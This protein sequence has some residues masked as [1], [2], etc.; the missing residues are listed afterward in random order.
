MTKVAILIP[1]TTCGREWR[2]MEDTYLYN[3]TLKTFLLSRCKEDEIEYIFYIGYDDGDKIL[4]QKC[5]Q[6]KIKKFEKVF[7]DIN[8]E[9]VCFQEIPKGYLT[10]MWN[11]LFKRAYIDGADY[12]FQCGDDINF[13]TNGWVSA[14]VETLKKH[15]NIGITGPINN[16]C[17]IL[18][19][20]MVSR[21]HMDIFGYF[22]PE[23]IK[24]W[25]CDDWYNLVYQPKL[26][27]P[28]ANHYCSNEGGNPRYVINNDENFRSL[29]KFRN[30]VEKLRADTKT[31]ANKHKVLLEKY[32]DVQNGEI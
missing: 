7:K 31:L 6:E 9:F 12:F 27:F 8:I 24:N 19:Q 13:R 17:R 28:L 32:I 20:C 16:N 10:K 21:C 11:V 5:E 3:L 4:S 25:C 2:K 23:E 15:N 22:F 14:C 18:T 1:S 30:N 26:F 29:N